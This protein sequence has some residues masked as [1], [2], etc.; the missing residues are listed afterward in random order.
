MKFIAGTLLCLFL[1]SCGTM[2]NRDVVTKPE[3]VVK[4]YQI[5]AQPIDN[6]DDYSVSVKNGRLSWSATLKNNDKFRT[7][8]AGII[9]V[10]TSVSTVVC[11]EFGCTVDP[12]K[13]SEITIGEHD[14][15]VMS[16]PKTW[17]VVKDACV[18]AL[19]RPPSWPNIP[20]WIKYK[21]VR[22]EDA[23]A[24]CFGQLVGDVSQQRDEY[25]WR[26]EVRNPFDQKLECLVSVSL[27]TS[28]GEKQ[29]KTEPGEVAAKSSAWVGGRVKLDQ[30]LTS[31]GAE[32]SASTK[33]ESVRLVMKE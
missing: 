18:L 2:A 11:I 30:P 15:A 13:T 19:G 29:V 24:H 26:Q 33:L 14:V 6:F 28:T 12:A 27:A 9:T 31:S 7:Y 3:V 1:L 23:D 4:N 21:T 16:M 25:V 32:V 20:L 8:I 17:S 5:H 22:V 10:Y